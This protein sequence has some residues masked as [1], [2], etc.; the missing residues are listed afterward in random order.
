[1]LTNLVHRT[2]V[3]ST[4]G[5]DDP[6]HELCLCSDLSAVYPAP[7]TTD[8]G[9]ERLSPLQRQLDFLL[10][11]VPSVRLT[12]RPGRTLFQELCSRLGP[13]F[14][15]ASALSKT[16]RQISGAF[17]CSASDDHLLLSFHQL[18]KVAPVPHSPLLVW[19]S[20][21]VP[22]SHLVSI[23]SETDMVHILVA[24]TT[25]SQ[26]AFRAPFY[27][28]FVLSATSLAGLLL[29]FVFQKKKRHPTMIS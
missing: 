14:I 15:C 22:L 4:R 2:S 9:Q 13:S 27:T 8:Q 28:L 11:R 24:P 29:L 19:T 3:L 20:P 7:E 16:S 25:A 1:M 21:S 17:L 26:R 6:F 23:S 12:R 10:M 5:V 18:S